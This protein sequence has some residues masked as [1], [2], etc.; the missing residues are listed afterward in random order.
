MSTNGRRVDPS[1]GCAYSFPE[2][3]GWYRAQG[4][5]PE[6]VNLFWSTLPP[7][8]I[9][10]QELRFS[11]GDRV[12]CNMGVRRLAGKV[13]DTNVEDPEEP[14][15]EELIAYVVKTDNLPGIEPSRTISAPA[16]EDEVICRE[17]CFHSQREFLLAKWAA[18]LKPDRKKALRFQLADSVIIRIRDGPDGYEQ[19]AQGKVIE[20]WQYQGLSLTDFCRPHLYCRTWSC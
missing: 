2:L 18:P 6:Q 7:Y 17:R 9:P 4:W 15:A 8:E 14:D 5:S 13:I 20:V 16:D 3:F 1:D 12:L 10:K 19:W 11:Q